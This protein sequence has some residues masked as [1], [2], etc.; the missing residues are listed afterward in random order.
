MLV[1]LFSLFF[2]DF[3]LLVSESHGGGEMRER[4]GEEKGGGNQPKILI[5]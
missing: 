2:Y 5:K 3:T 4:A 1:V